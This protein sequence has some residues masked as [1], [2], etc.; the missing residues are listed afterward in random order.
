M[1]K[2][3]QIGKSSVTGSFHLF[4]G[5]TISTVI[6]AVGTL[7]LGNLMLEG[8]YGLYTVALI[9]PL[10]I[11]LFQD[12]GVSYA[13]T[14][15]IAHNRAESQEENIRGIVIGGLLFKLTLGLALSCAL[16]IS[17]DYIATSVLNRPEAATLIALASVT[18][19]SDSLL[20]AA[21]SS[22]N[23][24]EKMKL[25]SITMVAQSITKTIVSPMLVI[26]GY[27]ALGAVLGHTFSLLFAGG[28]AVIMLYFTLVR[29]LPK[30]NNSQQANI[31]QILKTMLSFGAPLSISVI[32]SGFLVQF[33]AFVMALYCTDVMIG[34]YQI[35]ANFGVLLTFFTFPIT[36]VLFPAFSKLDTK[37]DPQLL[38]TLFSFSVK[39]T[40]IL[41][42]PATMA[43]MVLSKPLVCALFGQKWTHAPFFLTLYVVTYLFILLGSLIGGPLLQGTG[44]TTM[45]LKLALLTLFLGIPL[46]LI[47]IPALG[48]VGVILSPL[49]AGMP[50]LFWGLH[51]IWR[52]YKARV[53]YVSSAKILVASALATAVTYIFIN[54]SITTEWIQI[55][56]G[57]TIFVTVYILV[58]PTLGAITPSDIRNL[59]AM[60]SGLGPITK[61][62]NIPLTIAEKVAEGHHNL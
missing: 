13:M 37:D 39:Y 61:L 5:K 25:N 21:Q 8:E 17:A 28:I 46:A 53:D 22:F 56:I 41:L 4:T 34:N 42:V 1:D 32:L 29:S 62:V 58:A 55:A 15:Y 48:I 52:H 38:R 11:N 50:S 45:L 14:K 43:M 36:T 60:L 7:F 10:M 59:R 16:M 47:L 12:W 49:V 6:M 57:G 2:A 40:A 33:Y 44:Q 54:F 9:P 26:L 3:L 27:G 23:G 30:R 51:W 18:I 31:V 20:T 35:A 19:F 24:F